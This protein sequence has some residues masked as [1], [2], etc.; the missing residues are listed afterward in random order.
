MASL[1]GFHENLMTSG[2]QNTGSCR[3]LASHA[4]HLR[5]SEKESGE[6]EEEKEEEE[7]E[8]EEEE[9]EEEEAG[10]DSG[11]V[12]GRRVGSGGL[13]PTLDDCPLPPQTGKARA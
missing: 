1:M 11:H 4:L 5:A 9:E 10:G 6:E 12:A 2:K 8:E 13:P 7:K 3:L